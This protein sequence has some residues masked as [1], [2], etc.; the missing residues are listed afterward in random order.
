MHEDAITKERLK[1][2]ALP[3]TRN[4]SAE[5]R[6]AKLMPPVGRKDHAA[7]SGWTARRGFQAAKNR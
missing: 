2:K 7:G 3:L 5:A 6:F 4:A 1:I